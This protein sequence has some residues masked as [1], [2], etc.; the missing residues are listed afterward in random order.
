MAPLGPFG[1]APRLAAGV[2][3]GPH[4]LAL[5]LLADRWARRR[6]GDV[7]ALVADHGLRP[8]SAA[9]AAHVHGLLAGCGVAAQVVRLGLAAGPSMQ[10]RARAARLAARPFPAAG[11][12]RRSA[13]AATVQV[14]VQAAPFP[15][16]AGRA[17]RRVG[18]AARAQRAAA[19]A[20]LPGR[21]PAVLAAVLAGTCLRQGRL[22]AAPA[23]PGTSCACTW[24]SA[25]CG[26]QRRL[27]CRARHSGSN[28]LGRRLSCQPAVKHHATARNKASCHGY[29][30]YGPFFHMV[31]QL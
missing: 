21:L 27:P 10:E 29:W 20:G 9:E 4:S 23:P 28:M 6:G 5:A 31:W 7:L 8:E 18:R 1:P 11:V 2:S 16:L 17:V 30:G 15:G 12:Q 13:A 14:T 3:G 22:P 26:L 19:L 25:P 24:R